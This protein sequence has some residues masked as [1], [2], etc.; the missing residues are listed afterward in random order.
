[1]TRSFAREPRKALAISIA[2]IGFAALSLTLATPA[3]AEA[4]RPLVRP[5]SAVKIVKA[6]MPV[7]LKDVLTKNLVGLEREDAATRKLTI[8]QAKEYIEIRSGSWSPARVQAWLEKCEA[9]LGKSPENP[10]CQ[11]E[12]ERVSPI[13]ASTAKY[14]SVIRE[15]RRALGEDLKAQRFGKAAGKSYQDVVFALG[16]LGDAN[17]ILPLAKK[18]AEA[19]ECLPPSVPTAM[20]YKLEELFPRTEIVDLAKKLYKKGSSCGEDFAAATASFRLGLITVWGKSCDGVIELMHKTEKVADASQFHARAKFWR[21]YCGSASKNEVAIKEAREALLKDHPMSYQ[22]LAVNGSDDVAM[23]SI[24]EA[25]IPD[26]SMR[27]IIRPDLNS[28]LRATEALQRAGSSHLASELIERRMSDIGTLE[29]E[30]R[31]YLAGFLHKLGYA[32]PKFRIL[33]SLFTDAP[34]VVSRATIELMF[35]LWYLDLVRAKQDQVDPLLILSLIRQESA[36]NPQA[37]SSVGARGLMQVMPATAR[38]IA[39]VKKNQLFDPKINVG[40]GTK[41][42]T[43]RLQ[44]YGGDVELTLAAYNAGFGRV[45]QWLK[46][47]PTDNKHLFLDFIPFKET[48]D[49]VSSILRNYY[50]YVR[51]YDQVPTIADAKVAGRAV[52]TE[53]GSLRSDAV[54]IQAIMGA[55]AGIVAARGLEENR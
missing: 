19:R 41:Y 32:L 22:N 17:A 37:M 49:Y 36:F 5:P 27:S 16:S 3:P 55:N 23:A 39:K 1:M 38:S 42:F 2:S 51:L 26:V 47:Y 6:N 12:Q 24:F 33:S 28:I 34:R 40:V 29:P 43:K 30:V 9:A 48:R 10:F 35:P 8:E 20:G 18:A 45:D 7:A 53:Q 31:L 54:K 11:I 13:A 50:F 46:R 15:E 52:A 14:P 21:Y 4:T 25:S 44:Q